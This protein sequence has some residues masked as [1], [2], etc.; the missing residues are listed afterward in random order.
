MRFADFGDVSS[1]KSPG[2]QEKQIFLEKGSC[3]KLFQVISLEKCF[4]LHA[5]WSPLD[6]V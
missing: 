2:A 6:E 1:R 4:Y 3:D 5:V